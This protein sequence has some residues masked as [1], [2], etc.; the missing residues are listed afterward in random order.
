MMFQN[1]HNLTKTKTFSTISLDHFSSPPE[2]LQSSSSTR[3]KPLHC[4][5][6]T[7]PALYHHYHVTSLSLPL[8]AALVPK[9]P[10]AALQLL[11][12]WRFATDWGARP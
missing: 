7:A 6:A 12:L 2:L 8:T 3:P 1:A 10:P 5:P 11:P 4:T 9:A